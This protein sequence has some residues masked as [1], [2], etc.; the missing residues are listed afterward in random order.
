MIVSNM[1]AGVA[2]G[3]VSD[4]PFQSKPLHV[5]RFDTLAAL[6]GAGPDWDFVQDHC[7]FH[8]VLLDHRWIRAWWNAFGEGKELHGLVI[9]RDG[10][11]VGLAPMVLSQGR[12]AWP[13]RDSQLQ[14]AEDHRNL[15]VPA[16]RRVV[17]VRRV[18]F[19]LN[20]PCH[21]SRSHV[22]IAD[23]PAEVC[24]AVLDY[25][26][27]RQN[28]WDVM[29]L[30]GLPVSSGQREMFQAA[31]AARGLP[32][33]PHGRAREMYSADLTGGM[34]AYLARR[35]SHFRKRHRAQMRACEKAGRFEV[36]Q[37]RGSDIGRGLDAM[38]DIESQTWKARPEANAPVRMPIDDRL[39]RFFT[40]VAYAYAANDDAVI[41]VMNLDGRPAGCL[42]GLSRG[43]VMLS[44]V[45]YLRDDMRD[46]LNAAPLWDSLIR[47]ATARNM[48]ELDIHG[49]TAYARKWATR[50]ETYQRLYVFSAHLKG[51]AL[52]A[53][54]ALA[55][56]LSRQLAR[57]RDGFKGE[58]DGRD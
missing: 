29:M 1:P 58:H 48:T 51:R 7:P 27:D 57:R 43:N 6:D 42:F 25:W 9:R 32:S 3:F 19:P 11:P 30:D 28:D 5:G 22:L 13:S 50:E 37:Y 12:E 44:L 24:A 47:D 31:A 45:V 2:S 35:G 33:L 15:S 18:T 49:V 53:S 14:I 8:H 40:E 39:R 23:D 4:V 36:R 38:F 21:N 56:T 17:P 10:T 34:E 54:K 41:H 55:T 20:V 16:W 52:W 46:I 26:K